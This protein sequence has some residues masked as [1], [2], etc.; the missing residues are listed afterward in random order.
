MGMTCFKYKN[1]KKQCFEIFGNAVTYIDEERCT[2]DEGFKECIFYKMITEP[3]DKH[4]K[5]MEACSHVASITLS[6]VPYADMKLLCET[7]C[8]NE[9]NRKNCAIYKCFDEL[10]RVPIGLLPDGRMIQVNE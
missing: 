7:Y 8:L 3:E 1:N 10:E 5:Y 9:K 6:Q 4:C 2:S